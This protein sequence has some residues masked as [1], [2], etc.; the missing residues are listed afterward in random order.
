M[1]DTLPLTAMS[2]DVR[3]LNTAKGWRP[4]E[5]GP[6][7]K[8][9][10]DYIALLHTE[11]GEATEDKDMSQ[12]PL[13]VLPKPEG[14]GA[15]LADTLIRFLDLCDVFAIVPFDMDNELADVAPAATPTLA[16]DGFGTMTACLH[17]AATDCY[18]WAS[19]PRDPHHVEPFTVFLRMLVR[20]AEQ[21]GV[22]LYAEYTRKMAH[23]WTR[24]VRHGGKHL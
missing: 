23:N 1:T 18:R 4:A 12:H 16:T 3:A 11:I 9:F 14:V 17:A 22:D 8:T 19:G 5:G 24:P 21:S 15:E 20:V 13:G 10:G 2:T 6:G 7:D